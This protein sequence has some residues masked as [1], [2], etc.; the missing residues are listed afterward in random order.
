[1]TVVF[2]RFI[3]LCDEY[4]SANGEIGPNSCYYFSYKVRL[5]LSV[6]LELEMFLTTDTYK[7]LPLCELTV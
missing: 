3:Y 2:G 5:T 6:I 4:L 1:M 7:K